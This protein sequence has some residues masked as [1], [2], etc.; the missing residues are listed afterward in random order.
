MKMTPIQKVVVA[1]SGVMP[2]TRSAGLITNTAP[3]STRSTTENTRITCF[4]TG[5]SSRPTS[6][7]SESPPE[8]TD[9]MAD[10]KS[11]TAPPKMVPATI[12]MKAAGPNITPMMAPKIGPRPAIFRNWMRN[13]FHTGSSI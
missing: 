9:I 6:S 3:T 1:H 4:T 13:T 7:G 8:R 12:H 10:M 5:P 2:A 11:C